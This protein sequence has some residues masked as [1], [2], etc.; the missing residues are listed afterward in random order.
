MATK[1]V[2]LKFTVHLTDPAVFNALLA[3]PIWL[4]PKNAETTF[5]API[6]IGNAPFVAPC[7]TSDW[8]S[9]TA[10]FPLDEGSFERCGAGWFGLC[11]GPFGTK[12]RYDWVGTFVLAPTLAGDGSP[13]AGEPPVALAKRRWIDGAEL[14]NNG[15]GGSCGSQVVPSRGSSR[16]LNGFGYHFDSTNQVRS[17]THIE[18]G[19]GPFSAAWER[20][21]L[22][23]HRFD[24]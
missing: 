7:I 15:Q 3:N 20:F 22:R 16:H 12:T 23:F 21:Y 2:Y 4:S 13:I 10:N 9:G 14:P 1:T 19:G 5:G 11:F 6:L 24:P 18:N 17:H 8:F